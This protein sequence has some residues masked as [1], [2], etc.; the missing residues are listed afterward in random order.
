MNIRPWLPLLLISAA[1]VLHAEPDPIQVTDEIIVTGEAETTSTPDWQVYDQTEL[2]RGYRD[3]G[4]FLQQVN[5]LQVQTLGREGD[6]VVV[7]MRGANA[8]Q[9]RVLV[10]GIAINN[11]QYGSYDLNAIPMNQIERIEIIQAGSDN[12]AGIMGDD[13]I[14]GTI[15]IVT[16][17][18]LDGTTRIQGSI[19]SGNSFS[20]SLQQPLG[21]RTSLL[22]DH[23]ESDNNGRYPVASPYADPTNRNDW[24]ALRNA[25][26]EHN[27][28]LLSHRADILTATVQVQDEYKQLPDY[29]RNSPNNTASLANRSG[30]LRLEGD[31][32]LGEQQRFYQH[33]Q[34]F[35]S[36]RH[37]T[38]RDPQK[39]LGQSEDDNRYRYTQS[40]GQFSSQTDV[41]SWTFTGQLKMTEQTYRSRYLLDQ[42]AVACDS[43][44]GHCNQFSWMQE[45]EAGLQSVWEGQ[46]DQQ[47][48]LNV[49]HH[50][51]NEMARPDGNNDLDTTRNSSQW[52]SLM[53]SWR[54]LHDWQQTHASW[55][56]A[57]K[58]ARRLPSLYE[59]F[60][61]HGLMVG[62]DE[63]L[64]EDSITISLDTT[65]DTELAGRNQSLNISLFNRE[66]DNAIVAI[67][68]DT[69]A[70]RY[71]NTSSAS[72]QG[73][74]W[75][76]RS[77]LDGDNND[78]QHWHLKLAGSHYQSETR[79]DTVKSLD[80][81]QLAGIYH[82]RGLASIDWQ[83][84]ARKDSIYQIELAGE[85]ADDLWL[86]RS[87][88]VRGDQR[89]LMNLTGSYQFGNS[90]ADYCG[91]T[92][93]RIRNLTNHFFRDY[94]GRPDNG[95]QW[96]LYITL[97][98]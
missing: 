56:V 51:R 92:G 45:S 1:P 82:Q 62:N 88:L 53:S 30:Y 85:L 96:S 32:A 68:E 43:L 90:S 13:A 93:L 80:G 76:L 57:V 9:T 87:N 60:G 16:R 2:S 34:L 70:G 94:T 27:S 74:E 23:R 44:V 75:Q 6:P 26:Y 61:D 12:S 58:S 71:E 50:Q 73:L 5:G 78:N 97:Y 48:L 29:Y 91:E 20:T 89:R 25:R 4:D 17:D 86:D 38:Y 98:L 81:Q 63:L 59:R 54:Q 37:E 95:R 33:W 10:N 49:T 46:N 11:S 21:D 7:S 3:L 28:L 65:L 19:G 40:E 41:A 79:S 47:W 22:Y 18:D 14:G 69:G 84:T 67:Y 83:Y 64:P 39:I 55:Q 31:F 77:Q 8:N 24:Q 36:L 15:N 42:D 72:M 52:P 66:L 35:Q